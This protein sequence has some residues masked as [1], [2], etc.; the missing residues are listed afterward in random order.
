[1]LQKLNRYVPTPMSSQQ[2]IDRVF[3]VLEAVVRARKP[4][5]MAEV[6]SSLDMPGPTVHRLVVSL[7]ER[8]LLKR[9]MGSKKLLPGT[10]L[11]ELSGEVMESTLI[12]DRP[13]AVLEE[14]AVR[15]QEHCQIGLIT[16]GEVLYID[17]V[18]VRRTHG[19]QLEQGR[20]AP[21]HCTS[22]GKLFLASLGDAELS[23]WLAHRTLDKMTDNTITNHDLLR[24]HLNSVRSRG[25]GTSNEEYGIGV[26][27]C[28]V[29]IPSPVRNRFLAIGISAPAARCSFSTVGEFVE[30]LREAAQKIGLILSEEAHGVSA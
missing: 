29:R 18:R 22:M 10:R 13:H 3:A 19:L 9:A 4:V 8:G 27:G 12:T 15:L 30:P 17:A 28:A 7:E 16:K 11:L 23:A 21:L 25:F 14:L 26:V 1:M 20:S 24:E 6:A 5:G 2:P